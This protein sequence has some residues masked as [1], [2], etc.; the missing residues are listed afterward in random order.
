MTLKEM[1]AGYEYCKGRKRLL[2]GTATELRREHMRTRMVDAEAKK[3]KERVKAVKQKMARES[4]GKMWN[5]IN[6]SQKDPR[7]GAF[8]F[9]QRV[10]CVCVFVSA[11]R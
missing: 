6:R 10:V 3:D 2:L 11:H 5:F 1:E 9:V 7:S 4:G 8:H